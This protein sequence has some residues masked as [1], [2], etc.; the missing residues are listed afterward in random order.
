ML[1]LKNILRLSVGDFTAKSLY[2]I[3]FIYLARKLGPDNYGVLELSISILAYFILIADGGLELWAMREI[4][5]KDQLRYL[6][7]RILPLRLLFALMAYLLLLS[8]LTVF[9]GYPYLRL[10]LI[11]FG[12]SL[13]ANGAS[14]KWAFIGREMMTRASLGMIIAQVV[15]ALSIF[16]FVHHPEQI[17]LVPIFKV[18]GDFSMAAFFYYHFTREV[19][20]ERI[21]FTFRDTSPIL[22]PALTLGASGALAMMSYNLDVLLL[23]FLSTS[24][25]V[26]FYSAG[27]KP[28]TVVLVASVTYFLGLFP[29]LARNY[30][31]NRSAFQQIVLRALRQS[32]LVAIPIAVGGTLLAKPIIHLLFG[33]AYLNSVTV[34]QILSWSAMLV[35]LRGTLRRS[36]IASGNQKKDLICA[37]SAAALNLTLNLIL[38]P[39]YGILGAASATVMSE[40]LW[41]SIARYFFSRLGTGIQL[42]PQLMLPAFAG[43]F[44]GGFIYL[45]DS[46][47]WILRGGIGLLIYIVILWVT[48]EKEMRTLLQFRSAGKL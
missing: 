15:F 4:A 38:I 14:L 11:L 48:G 16:L 18:V 35:I 10:L 12:F 19:K 26:G 27:Y 36:L 30:T 47:T 31:H 37:G 8:L 1:P 43:M 32:S 39:R 41:L 2:F 6:V 13:I 23:G 5:R 34:M 3:A 46:M 28:L 33:S 24:R 42:L 45:T 9:P 40:L 22:L 17:I 21:S 29:S 25:E 7:E 20:G 44:M